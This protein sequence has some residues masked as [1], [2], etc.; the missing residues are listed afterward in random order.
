MLTQS[1]Q[2]DTGI[3]PIGIYMLK[4]NNRNTKL[5]CEM[6]SKLTIKIPELRHSRRFCVFI[7]NF[8]HISHLVLVFLLINLDM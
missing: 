4:V 8:E 5:R 1:Q 2:E 3:A 6:W 7:V